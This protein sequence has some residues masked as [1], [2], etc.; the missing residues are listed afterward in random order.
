MHRF[1]INTSLSCESILS[2]EINL[3]IFNKVIT[4]PKSQITAIIM[5]SPPCVYKEI[6]N[7]KNY[8]VNGL[9]RRNMI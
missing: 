9:K 2:L 7:D 3:P 1:S 8:I 6:I 5:T 4:P